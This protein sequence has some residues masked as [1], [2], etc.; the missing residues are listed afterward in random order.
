MKA[1]IY[2][3][4]II[5]GLSM[6]VQAIV[7]GQLRTS[8]GSPYMAAFISFATGTIALVVLNIILNQPFG[9]LKTLKEIPWI[10]LTGGTLGVIVVTSV[11]LAVQKMP[12]A[13]MF[14]LLVTSQLIGA[15]I[16]D[17]NGWLGVKQA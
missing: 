7:N 13:N 6:A 2:F 10:Q 12:S 4:P 1:F 9:S 16:L 3:L 15:L 11:I 14:V 8:V 5:A 17:H